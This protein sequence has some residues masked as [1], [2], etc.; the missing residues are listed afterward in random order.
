M[1]RH[2]VVKLV[3]E[4]AKGQR[5]LPPSPHIKYLFWRA[6]TRVRPYRPARPQRPAPVARR[7][8][9]VQAAMSAETP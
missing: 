7:A 2:R 8:R 1:G 3:G 5:A 9:K 4:E 6:H